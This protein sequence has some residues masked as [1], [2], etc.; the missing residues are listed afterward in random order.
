M[1]QGVDA[2]ISLQLQELVPAKAL[3]AAPVK[4]AKPDEA[5]AKCQAMLSCCPSQD[6]APGND[7]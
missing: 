1:P 4:D 5:L 6:V 2:A 7:D 3:T